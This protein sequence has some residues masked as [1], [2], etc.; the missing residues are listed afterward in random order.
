MAYSIL[1]SFIEL[2]FHLH[3]IIEMFVITHMTASVQW[4]N[5]LGD[6]AIGEMAHMLPPAYVSVT[7]SL[8]V[9]HKI[10]AT[11]MHTYL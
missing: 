3:R 1:M 8:P 2:K 6:L 5:I 9:D 7:V 10:V 4:C 11:F